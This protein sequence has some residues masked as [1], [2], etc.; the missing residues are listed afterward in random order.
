MVRFEKTRVVIMKNCVGLV[1]V[2]GFYEVRM[3][4]KLQCNPVHPNLLITVEKCWIAR[5]NKFFLM[6]EIRENG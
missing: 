5:I 3:M 2:I 6:K 1:Q 4:I